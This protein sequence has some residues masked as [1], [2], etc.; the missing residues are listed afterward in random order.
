MILGV[1]TISGPAKRLISLGIASI[2]LAAADNAPNPVETI[3]FQ[4]MAALA[5]NAAPPT[6]IP[7][8]PVDIATSDITASDIA[9]SDIVTA[10]AES[11]PARLTTLIASLESPASTREHACLATAVY[12]EARGEPLEGQLAV[13]QAI[14]N[15]AASGRYPNTVCGV[16]NQPRQFSYDRSRAP[17]AGSDWATAQAIAH[18]AARDMWHQVAPKAMSFHAV[19]VA[20]AWRGKTRVAQIGRHIFYR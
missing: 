9:T 6:A 1:S 17:R 18:V 10:P 5:E 4:P 19:H 2:F 14:L 13:A 3:G 16:V 7:T 11:R 15:R 8:A 12:F 20:P